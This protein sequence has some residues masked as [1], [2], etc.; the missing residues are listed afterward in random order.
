MCD[1]NLAFQCLRMPLHL[2]KNKTDLGLL[3]QYHISSSSQA[4]DDTNNRLI[5]I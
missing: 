3:Q 5:I 2:V 4:T 1:V